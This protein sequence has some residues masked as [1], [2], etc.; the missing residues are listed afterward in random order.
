[1]KYPIAFALLMLLAA[2][3]SADTASLLKSIIGKN[4]T[5]AKVSES[6]INADG[7]LSGVYAGTSYTGTWSLKGGQYCRK[8]PAFKVNGCQEIVGVADDSGKITAVEFRDPG[9]SKGNRYKIN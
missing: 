7:T 9:A 2:P 4:L 1:M 6:Y 5:N 8:I 3:A